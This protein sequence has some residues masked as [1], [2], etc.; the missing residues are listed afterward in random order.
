MAKLRKEIAET[1][2]FI[3]FLEETKRVEHIDQYKRTKNCIHVLEDFSAIATKDN[4]ESIEHL[5][6]VNREYKDFREHALD[7]NRC[8]LSLDS[9]FL[10]K[11]YENQKLFPEKIKKILREEWK[12]DSD[13]EIYIGKLPAPGAPTEFGSSRA[14]L[15][16][17]TNSPMK[18]GIEDFQE[19]IVE[20]L[21]LKLSDFAIRLKKSSKNRG[22]FQA[23]AHHENNQDY[24]NISIRSRK[25]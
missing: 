5:H 20:P 8:Q 12:Y 10:F 2:R 4:P 23:D 24:T 11:G 9:L 25:K 1:K 3:E 19:R 22:Y 18:K 17:F 21:G 15:V 14:R 6:K 7:C 13:K 16:Y